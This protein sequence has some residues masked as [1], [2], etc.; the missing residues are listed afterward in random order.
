M[1]RQARLSRLN[2]VYLAHRHAGAFFLILALG[3]SCGL[4][5]ETFLAPRT[6]ESAYS[7]AL[8][9]SVPDGERFDW[10]S[11]EKEW[12]NLLTRRESQALLTANLRAAVKN[13]AAPYAPASDWSAEQLRSELLSFKT[14]KTYSTSPHFG[15]LRLYYG[16]NIEIARHDLAANL[17]FQSLAKIVADLDPQPGI[18]DWDLSKY[19][20]RLE[21]LS[22]LDGMIIKP[23]ADDPHFAIFYRLHQLMTG[24]AATSPDQA[25]QTAVNEVQDRIVRES[26]FQGGGGF[27]ELARRELLLE[28]FCIPILAPN[29]LYHMPD[30]FS[31][32][33]KIT[34]YEEFWRQRWQYDTKLRLDH[35]GSTR[36]RLF[37]DMRYNL[38]PFLFPADSPVTRIAPVVV[39]TAFIYIEGWEKLLE[40]AVAPETAA[41]TPVVF[42][43]AEQQ[44]EELGA[45]V[46][47]EQSKAEQE[48]Q[49][50]LLQEEQKAHNERIAKLESEAHTARVC[51]D[52][53]QRE[54]EAERMA[55]DSLAVEAATAGDRADRLREMLANAELMQNEPQKPEI[56]PKLALLLEQKEQLLLYIAELLV[57]CTE[58]H[59]FVVEARRQL[60][61]L[62]SRIALCQPVEET[63]IA[64]EFQ[65]RIRNLRAEWTAADNQ[66]QTLAERLRRSREEADRLL[67]RLSDQEKIVSDAEY[68][69]VSEKQKEIPCVDTS[70]QALNANIGRIADHLGQLAQKPCPGS[71]DGL[72]N[73]PAGTA[74]DAARS[75]E[76]KVSFSSLP[77][78]LPLV[79]IAPS[80]LPAIIGASLGLCLGALLTMLREILTF[81]IGNAYI[82]QRL[83]DLPLLAV[84]PAYDAKSLQAAAKTEDGKLTAHYGRRAFIPAKLDLRDPPPLGKRK[85]IRKRR[86]PR[87]LG[88]WIA[89]AVILAIAL[90]AHQVVIRGWIV[91]KPPFAS[92]VWQRPPLR[93]SSHSQDDRP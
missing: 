88:A 61:A 10:N 25:W 15:H 12:S 51:R 79:R 83:V 46:D 20:D 62:E 84:L 7:R 18:Q 59:P 80:N 3:I 58:E 44:P 24:K 76:I 21:S 14:P 33:S 56:D 26:E 31:P 11:K 91:P 36:G 66:A 38:L 67:R 74:P 69:L 93:T 52:R 41:A 4:L 55:I 23:D 45:G 57:N 39:R 71:N 49:L 92:E 86:Q 43:D 47:T 37:L 27:G 50:A 53:I 77:D 6:Y 8:V 70:V 63:P 28:L 40:R 2:P 75:Q 30:V 42:A 78:T 73:E 85:A 29:C 34:P 17:D 90:A 64:N 68:A 19:L 87:R 22:S 13:L 72:K 1:N 5:A 35:D 32:S 89:G 60:A 81:K 54:L 16:P 48:K 65:T 9:V 82:A